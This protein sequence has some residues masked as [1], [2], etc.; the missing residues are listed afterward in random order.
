LLAVGVAGWVAGGAV[1]CGPAPK[2]TLANP[3]PSGRIP[4]IKH[5]GLTRDR[6]A[7]PD[8]VAALAS[9]D[10]AVRLAAIEA[11]RQI[12]GGEDFGYVW[13]DDDDKRAPAME[14][15]KQW[16]AGQE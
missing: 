10:P 15:W 5:A 14:R 12:T 9:D 4:A 8:L 11:L 7:A 3:D 2:K 16:L 6:K 13:F 1:G